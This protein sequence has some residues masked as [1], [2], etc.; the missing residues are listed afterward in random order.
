M[1]QHR[2]QEREAIEGTSKV[3]G[4]LRMSYTFLRFE[5][6]VSSYWLSTA[7]VSVDDNRHND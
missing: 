4:A 1:L 7:S 5:G 6:T 3:G 2:T